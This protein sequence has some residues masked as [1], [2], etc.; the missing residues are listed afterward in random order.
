MYIHAHIPPH[1]HTH[2]YMYIHMYIHTY[3][4]IR[5]SILFLWGLGSKTRRDKQKSANNL[6]PPF[7]SKINWC[8][9]LFLFSLQKHCDVLLLRFFLQPD[10]HRA[11]WLAELLELFS[12]FHGP[13]HWR[14]PV[15]N[16]YSLDDPASFR[17][18]EVRT[19][20]K[21]GKKI[22]QCGLILFFKGFAD[23]ATIYFN[24]MG[25]I[26]RNVSV[27]KWQWCVLMCRFT[28]RIS[29]SRRWRISWTL[30]PRQAYL[31]RFDPPRWHKYETEVLPI[32]LSWEF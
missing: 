20:E 12:S 8:S 32:I 2:I 24:L 6:L 19:R 5:S 10:D 17:N 26:G 31:S 25:C 3:I 21:H 23:N 30:L 4:H 15:T 18:R 14:V 29:A 11:A 27:N 7:P 16:F 13:L 22:I 1:T 28:T 9:L